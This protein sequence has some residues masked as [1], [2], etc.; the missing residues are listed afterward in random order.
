MKKYGSLLV[1]A[2]LLT[3]SA[4]GQ[5]VNDEA[6]QNVYLVCNAHIDP[7]WLWE[8]EEGAATAIS[9]FRVAADLCEQFDDFIFNHNEAILYQWVEEYE[10][11]LFKRI[12]DLVAQGKWHIMGGWYLQPDGNLPSG[13]S[14]VRQILLG[15]NY[16]EDKFKV[17]PSTAINLDPFGHS[18]GLVQIMA[19]TGYDSYLF[20]RPAGY[21]KVSSNFAWKGYDGSEIIG[22]K[23]L[24]HY[25]SPLG[26]A[27]EKIRT[28]IEEHPDDN[29]LLILWGVGNHGGGPSMIDLQ[30]ISEL[31]KNEKNTN[32]IHATPES[33]FA[34]IKQIKGE[35]PV[36]ANDINPVF[37]GCYTSQIRI[38]QKHR[39]LENELF[40]TEKMVTS[41][42]VHGLMEYPSPELNEAMETLAGS[43]FHDILPGSSIQPVEETSLRL[44]DYGL[45]ILSRIKT[46]AFY[47]LAQG[48]VVAKEGE[49][50]ILVYNPHPFPVEDVLEC[51][52]NLH[53]FNWSGSFGNIHVFQDGQEIPA[54]VE[55]EKSNLYVD[56]RKRVIF[57]A[58]LAPFQMN[59]FDCQVKFLPEK[60]APVIDETGAYIHFITEELKV[61]INKETGLIDVFKV[62][63]EDILTAGAFKPI[64]I[65]HNPDPW[66]MRY[67]EFRDVAGSFSLL[68]PEKS[69][70]I[71][72]IK[73]N[74]IAPVR[75]IEDGE[76]RTIV[77]ATFGYNDSYLVQRYYLPKEG[78]WLDVDIRVFWN[79]KDRMLKLSLPL[80]METQ[81]VLGQVA[82][83]VQELPMDGTES[84]AQ[85]WVAVV[86]GEG[87]TL[88]VLNNGTYACDFKD[89]ELRISLMR[90]PA[91]SAL[92]DGKSEFVP[93]DR[94][95]PRIDQGERLFGFRISAGDA[96]ERLSHVDRE[97]LVFNEEPM[98]VSFF[99]SGQDEPA[100]ELMQL[101]D[102]VGQVTTVKKSQHVNDLVVLLFEPT[103][104]DRSTR[105]MIPSMNLD[106]KIELKG[107]EIKTL[108]INTENQNITEA[109][110]LEEPY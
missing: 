38:K 109:N 59:R 89:N 92:T 25:N 84:V 98:A 1:L 91:Y 77:E 87:E 21:K 69:A 110:L 32:I 93:Q 80:Q 28:V 83:G 66:G 23:S 35:L 105:L 4:A 99:P 43:E 19:K 94:F 48:Q 96:T 68:S 33:Y 30:K 57:K 102:D 13:E 64:I 42:W 67:T 73:A 50:P 7:V 53:D 15:R 101:T 36:H 14:F 18:R 31:I 9:T 44:M 106:E 74:S 71:S 95:S 56:W 72:G 76:V 6:I 27:E 55:H 22:L 10:P 97:A 108:L 5:A 104:S 29:P 60:P 107:F 26:K 37:P 86:S 65:S 3:V 79:E 17:R 61:E 78:S 8:W 62:G 40:A 2:W 20:C 82:Y 24:T 52:L 54:Q 41:A 75:V 51:E 100:G 16:F 45:E 34:E 12:Q 88:S 63:G 81:K 11:A 85:K 70:E 46:R 47:A 49:I 90:S 103:G 39:E 58:T